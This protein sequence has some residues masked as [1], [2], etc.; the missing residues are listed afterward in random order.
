M[1]DMT[2]HKLIIGIDPDVYRS[3]VA[4]LHPDKKFE[5]TLLSFFQLRD[6]LTTDKENIKVVKIEAGHL[7][8]KSNFHGAK[9][10]RT[11]S[12]IGK[13][14]GAN[15]EVGKKIIEMCEHYDIPYRPVKPFR[16]VWKG[17]DGKITH[18]E[19]QQQLK[20]RGIAPIIGRTNQEERDAA[21]ICL[22]G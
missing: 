6:Y 11:A 15:N 20:F 21:L 16:K 1:V 4:V 9:N 19:L 12:R 17:P 18:D 10:I 3:G 22:I 7:N 14:V 2:K 13:N 5:I 8:S